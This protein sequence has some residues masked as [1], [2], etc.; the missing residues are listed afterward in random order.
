[1]N[2]FKEFREKYPNF[3]YDKYEIEKTNEKLI[4]KF[5]FEIEHLST[6]NPILEIPNDNIKL[7]NINEDILDNIVFNIGLVEAITKQQ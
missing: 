5:Y 7:T 3:I 4:I 6:F 2:K 1:M